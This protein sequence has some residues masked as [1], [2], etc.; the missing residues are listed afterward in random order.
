MESAP[1]SYE[2]AT[3][4]DYW[5]IIAGYVP[6][7]DL[8]SA[9]LV[10]SRWHA[11]FI[12][13]LW[14]NP[15][16][17]FSQENDRVYVALTKF[18]RTLQTA[19]LLVRSLTHTLHLPPAHAEIY[20]GPHSDWL[21]DI[22]ERLPNLQSLIVRG[23]PFFDHAALQSLRY[24]TPKQNEYRPP[25]HV[26]E[27]PGSNGSA[28][29][30]AGPLPASFGLR[31]LDAS[32][33]PNVTASGLTQA[34]GRFETLMYLDLSFTYPARE[35]TVLHAMQRLSGLQVLKLR[36]I[37]LTDTALVTLARAIGLRIRSLDIRDNRITDRGV[38]TLLDH[39]FLPSDGTSPG[40]RSPALLPYLGGDMLGI[41]QGEE[42]EG[43]LRTTFTKAFV[44][45][46]AIEDVP[47]GGITHLYI[48][49]NQVSVEGA[50]GLIRS[51]RMH[52]LDLGSVRSAFEQHPSLANSDGTM[53]EIE[54]PGVEK[55]TGVLSKTAAEALTFLRIDHGL[56]TRDVPLSKPDEVV[57]GRVELGDTALP[58]MPT[59]ALELDATAFHPD[60]FELPT[61]QTP[62]FELP[63]D[64]MQFVVSPAINDAPRSPEDDE[65]PNG[66]RGS[67]FA[68][69]LLDTLQPHNDDSLLSP[70]SALD[71]STGTMMSH[72][73]LASPVD[74]FSTPQ[75]PIQA[76]TR[77]RSYSSLGIER[78]AR[79]TAHLSGCHN[80][81]PAMLPHLSTLMLTNVPPMTM[82]N[83]SANRL[84]S[85]IK[86]SGEEER[87]AT[88]Q[89]RLD[90]ALP[91]GRRGHASAIRHSA[92]KNFALK[93]MV[94]EL[95]ENERPRKN[96]KASP[97]Q[98]IAT[99][100]VTDDRDSEALWS[101]AETDFSFFGEGDEA[102]F[103]SLE[104]GRYAHSA[105]MSEKEV[106][107]GGNARRP[108]NN[109]Q[110][111]PVPSPTFDTVGI[112]STF[113]RERKL[114]HERAL[115]A[116]S[117]DPETEGYWPG[118]VQVVRTS[119]GVRA[120]EELDYYGNTYSGG[121]LYR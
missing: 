61:E 98:H 87:L 120:D 17:H 69:E 85:F 105:G 93:R 114:A 22:L 97:W 102:D 75:S 35:A 29:E 48:S 86:Q 60:V 112:L 115:A 66:R 92:N 57:R 32:R 1:P 5:N 80:L 42:F 40:T 10:C 100:S 45:R 18:K 84:I 30:T 34:L 37:S 13:H 121:Y 38:R 91:P 109:V 81:H 54:L 79:L 76:T 68:P 106:S 107:F 16:S 52:V 118:L 25:S 20:N 77:P 116:G 89:A 58:L 33:C 71:D 6:S 50:S 90:Y 88:A 55:L 49:G 70:I 94:L 59:N 104:P 101:A 14:G 72:F 23:L 46:L 28:F 2:H 111:P 31:L 12:P 15:A 19:R 119:N 96:S 108:S 63:G 74:T 83:E 73:T 53:A 78:K 103:P 44:S 43:Y 9:A 3:L 26:I 82:S 117:D 47:Q 56:I 21:R 8:C 36:S 95:G 99:K 11:T 51:G 27:L 4:T 41:Y 7:N 24:V 64:P 113:R 65:P 39:N 62:R 67:A 110:Q